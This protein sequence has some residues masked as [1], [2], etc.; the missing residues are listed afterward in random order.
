[1]INQK[2]EL[3]LMLQYATTY[4]EFTSFPQAENQLF[5]SL[6]SSSPPDILIQSNELIF[7]KTPLKFEIFSEE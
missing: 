6:K 1:M 2:Q 7:F 5:L 4:F 3:L